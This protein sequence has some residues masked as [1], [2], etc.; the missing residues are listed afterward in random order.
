MD[1]GQ[2]SRAALCEQ[3]STLVTVQHN[4]EA[5]PGSV[6]LIIYP[7]IPAIKLHAASFLHLHLT[8]ACLVW[9]YKLK[10]GLFLYA[11]LRKNRNLRNLGCLFS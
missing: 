6:E 4:R 11:G 2:S 8:N 1:A 9:S 3:L 7:G 10:T 5:A